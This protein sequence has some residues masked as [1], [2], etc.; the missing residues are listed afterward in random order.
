VGALAPAGTP[1]EIVLKW[2][3]EIARILAIP[4]V[5][6]RQIAAGLEP[7]GNTP[8]QFAQFMRLEMD[9]WARVVKRA[10]IKAD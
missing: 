3:Q 5:K 4:E 2:Q 10:G 9:K 8:E 6:N 1:P 7:V